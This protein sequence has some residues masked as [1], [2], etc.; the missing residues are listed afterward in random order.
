MITKQLQEELSR[1]GLKEATEKEYWEYF[2]CFMTFTKARKLE[3]QKAVG[4]AR[5]ELGIF[6]QNLIIPIS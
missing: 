1:R 2:S 3:I 4:S 6:K 5:A